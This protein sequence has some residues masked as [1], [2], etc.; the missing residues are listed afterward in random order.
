MYSTDNAQSNDNAK[1]F[2]DINALRAV[3]P[4]VKFTAECYHYRQKTS[5][6]SV[7]EKIV[8]HRGEKTI[9][10]HDFTDCSAG[11]PDEWKQLSKWHDPFDWVSAWGGRAAAW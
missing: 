8:T 10:L 5:Q 2:K 4:Q 3:A 6:D 1:A 7:S 9:T 11:L